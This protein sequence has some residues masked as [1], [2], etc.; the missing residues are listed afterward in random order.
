MKLVLFGATGMVG[1][2]IATEASARGHQVVAVSR[3]GQSPVPGVASTAADASDP[4]KVAELVAG[5]D[6]VGSAC[7]PPRDGSD[8]R[9]PFLVLNQS[10]V[11]G[12]RTA[13]VR[14]LVIVGGAGTLEVAPGQA[15]CDQPDFPETYLPEALAHRDALAFYRA[16]VDDLDWT[17][18]SPAAEIGPGERTGE[19]RIGGDRMLTDAEG[20]SRISAED[21]AM[22]FVDQLEMP[23]H[24]NGRM[25]VAY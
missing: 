22:A 3:S 20:R 19:F 17:Y 9:E 16:Y 25:S 14:R 4:A 15:A 7:V 24:P 1:S 13:G 23:V 5:A 10:L 8:P 6:A 11:D 12:V 2:R 21:Y 18:I